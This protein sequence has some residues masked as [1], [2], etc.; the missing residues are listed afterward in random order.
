MAGTAPNMQEL[1]KIAKK[2]NINIVEDASHAM[3]ANY[4]CGAKVGSC[5]YSIASIFSF[6]PVKIVASGEGGAITTN[7]RDL[8]EKLI[9]LRSHG[10][11]SNKKMLNR[12]EAFSKGKKNIWYYEMQSLGF[13]YRQTE[14]HAAL[15]NSQLDK[16]DR[17]LEKRRKIA[18]RYDLIFKK[19]E[20][21]QP[22]QTSY[23]DISS[24]HLY[25][26][27]INF[28][29]IK[30]SRNDFMQK[31]RNKNII[32]QVH[33][34]PLPF[35]PFYQ[36]LGFSMKDLDN[37]KKYYKECLSLPIYYDLSLKQQDYVI[38][39]ILELTNQKL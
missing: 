29:K 23:R 8:Y 21:I 34:I 33:Y 5:K 10:I 12:N 28:A 22:L 24:N 30:I 6:H 25:I 27:K 32:T 2:N 11:I 15:L 35:H 37:S 9:S 13:H 7:N 19:N 38:N 3:G 17:F 36:N 31:L 39:S 1:S 26:V 4:S 20:F 14:I 18:K 16:I